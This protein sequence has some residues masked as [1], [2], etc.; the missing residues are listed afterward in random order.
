[1]HSGLFLQALLRHFDVALRG[2][3]AAATGAAA[4]GLS[5]AGLEVGLPREVRSNT[6]ILLVPKHD[7]RLWF[8][9]LAP[10]SV[11]CR[12]CACIYRAVHLAAVNLGASLVC[13][14][15]AVIPTLHN[16]SQRLQS[17]RCG[18]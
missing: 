4:A 13:D 17:P 12:L 6:A 14:L 18:L 2:H 7:A 16:G 8:R 5:A 11:D 15:G 1:M 3:I 9:R 10:L